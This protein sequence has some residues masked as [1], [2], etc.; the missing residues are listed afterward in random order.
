MVDERDLPP[1]TTRTEDVPMFLEPRS[2]DPV[3]SFGLRRGKGRPRSGER[4]LARGVSPGDRDE[5]MPSPRRGRQIWAA[6]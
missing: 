5:K 2:G 1:P 3:P 6:A 4:C